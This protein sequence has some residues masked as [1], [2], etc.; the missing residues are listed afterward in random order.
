MPLQRYRLRPTGYAYR[1]TSLGFM[2]DP[3]LLQSWWAPLLK[4]ASREAPVDNECLGKSRQVGDDG[5]SWSTG[6]LDHLQRAFRYLVN[7]PS[8]SDSVW[9][10]LW[11]S[12]WESLWVPLWNSLWDSLWDSLWEPRYLPQLQMAHIPQVL[13]AKHLLTSALTKTATTNASFNRY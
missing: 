7:S 5:K 9:N 11:D 1:I 10:S 4:S 13:R 8:P 6:Y 2:H 12:L 3:P